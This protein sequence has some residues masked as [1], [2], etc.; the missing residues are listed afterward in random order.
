VPLKVIVLRLDDMA[1]AILFPPPRRRGARSLLTRDAKKHGIIKH[2]VLR[3]TNGPIPVRQRRKVVERKTSAMQK[4]MRVTHCV[5]LL[6]VATRFRQI[7]I[8]VESK[9]IHTD[10]KFLT[11]GKHW[12]CHNVE[13]GQSIVQGQGSL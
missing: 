13:A 5:C 9:T 4:R 6:A 12:E 10:F 8:V 7:R 11:N 1:A 3:I 2:V